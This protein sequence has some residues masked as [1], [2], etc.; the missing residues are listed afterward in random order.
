M[1]QQIRYPTSGQVDRLHARILEVS[2][3]K[4]GYLSR[5]SLEYVLETV[6]HIGMNLDPGQSVMRRA[7]FLL[8][9]I[10]RQHPFAGGNKRTA[11]EL[12]KLFTNFNGYTVKSS[13]ETIYRM[14][15]DVEA[16]KLSAK[17]V[18]KWMEAN[19]VKSGPSGKKSSTSNEIDNKDFDDA[20]TRTLAEDKELLEMLS[21]M[22]E[23]A[24]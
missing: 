2:S 16:V 19:L 23:A 21:K 20:M 18:E 6:K 1:D 5:S 4:P 24:R 12:A 9:N 15:L 14:L 7:S 11:Y 22:S 8:Y 3:G 17:M 13:T 10:V